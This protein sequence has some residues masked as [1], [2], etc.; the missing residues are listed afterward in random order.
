[1]LRKLPLMQA[2]LTF[3]GY[4]NHEKT[5]NSPG[6]LRCPIQPPEASPPTNE[7]K[8]F[9]KEQKSFAEE[10][11]KKLRS[12]LDDVDKIAEKEKSSNGPRDSTVAYSA[13]GIICID[14]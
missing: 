7:Q 3:H 12:P 11:M 1:M 5:T 9:G 2:T 4:F 6:S 10:L 14:P 8:S 13:V